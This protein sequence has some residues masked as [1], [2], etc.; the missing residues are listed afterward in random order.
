M[1]EMQRTRQ[2]LQQIVTGL[3]A[4]NQSLLPPSFPGNYCVE[5]QPSVQLPTDRLLLYC[6]GTSNLLN[7][8]GDFLRDILGC[9]GAVIGGPGWVGRHSGAQY[10]RGWCLERGISLGDLWI[11]WARS[12]DVCPWCVE[13]QMFQRDKPSLSRQRGRRKCCCRR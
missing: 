3:M 1:N 12:T 4:G 11:T 5:M 8:F 7:R 10:I 9:Y 2:T 6:G 13:A